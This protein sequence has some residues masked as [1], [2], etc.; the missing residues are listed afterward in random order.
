M[1][2]FQDWAKTQAS[3]RSASERLKP[4]AARSGGERLPGEAREVSYEQALRASS[5]RRPADVPPVE[6]ARQ[7]QESVKAPEKK[8]SERAAEAQPSTRVRTASTAGAASAER[9]GVSPPVEPAQALKSAKSAA[10][11]TSTRG[12][13]G[14]AAKVQLRPSAT[15]PRDAPMTVQRTEAGADE[16]KIYSEARMLKSTRR[17]TVRAAAEPP[18]PPEFVA[19][20]DAAPPCNSSEGKR[21]R[22]S[23]RDVLRGTH[24]LGGVDQSNGTSMETTKAASLTLRVSDEE[25]ARIQACAAHANLS[26]SA[27]LRQCAM[28]VDDLR[29]Q[30]ELALAKLRDQQALTPPPPGLSAIPG[31]LRRFGLQCFHR[32]RPGRGESAL[33]S[34][35]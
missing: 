21:T 25:Q 18:V 17:V 11:N 22:P 10:L 19:A 33:L 29:D 27:Y 3:R 32:F 12:Q 2:R 34:I 28:G 15:S 16:K 26:V 4:A 8:A 14:R 24:S 20:P 9:K 7:E 6:V 30:V 13:K 35:R 31:I 5:Y 23:F 1:G